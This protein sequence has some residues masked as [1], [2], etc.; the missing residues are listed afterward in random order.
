MAC[1][2]VNGQVWG[3]CTKYSMNETEGGPEGMARR[4]RDGAYT[5]PVIPASPDFFVGFVSQI[6]FGQ[7]LITGPMMC[8]WEG[9]A[10]VRESPG[11]RWV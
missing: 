10:R 6:F 4:I 7:V 11:K 3:K 5:P 1:M 2:W 9:Q 8:G